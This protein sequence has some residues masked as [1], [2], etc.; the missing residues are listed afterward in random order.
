VKSVY[1]VQRLEEVLRGIAKAVD[2]IMLGEFDRRIGFAMTFFEFGTTNVANYI[3][4]ADRQDTIEVL[5][6][7]ADHLE[8][9]KDLPPATT[10][11]Q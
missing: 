8:K 10:A 2:S 3:S 4:N 9:G 5:R 1:E 6:A 11:V 7:L